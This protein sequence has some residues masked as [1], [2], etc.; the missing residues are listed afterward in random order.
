VRGIMP[1]LD[2]RRFLA[3]LPPLLAMPRLVAQ[4]PPPIRL[5]TFSHVTLAVSDLQ[6]SIDFYQRLFGLPVQVRQQKT[7]ASLR[8]GTGPHHLSLSTST[9]SGRTVPGVDHMCIGIDGFDLDRLLAHL[10]THGVARSETRG[11]MK[12][13]VRMRGTDA[14]GDKSGTPEVYI[15]DPDGI[16][17]QVQ[18]ASYC[19]GAG[20]LGNR[21]G[22]VEPSAHRGLMAPRFYSHCTVFSTDAPRSN[23][24]YQDVFGMGVRS[25]QGPTSP[26]LAVGPGVEFLMLT[27]GGG[28]TRTASIHHFCLAVDDFDVKRIQG[29]LEQAG[30]RPREGQSGAVP[31]MRHYVSMRMENRGGAKDGTPELYFTD[32][33]GILVQIQDV[34]YCGGSGTLG[35][36]CP[37]V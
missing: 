1:T 10:A 8:I 16:I 28:N 2:R 31:P 18:D 27:G 37:A 7:S 19:G 35:D 13:Q 9:S 20:P 11:P 24:F 5:R 12:V 36:V 23:R 32:P 25:Y 6:R 33:D 17:L 21:C 3:S 30:I 34:K 15:G 26:T 22:P 14:G 4:T 29:L